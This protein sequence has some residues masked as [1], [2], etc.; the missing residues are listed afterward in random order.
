MFTSKLY[1]K[2]SFLVYACGKIATGK[3]IF[4]KNGVIFL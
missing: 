2:S 3:W 4:A 1:A